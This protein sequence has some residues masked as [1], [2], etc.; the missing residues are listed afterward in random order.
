MADAL[1]LL[2]TAA[3]SALVVGAVGCSKDACNTYQDDVTAKLVQCGVTA[4]ST[5]PLPSE[6]TAP[7]AD[8]AQCLD[9]CIPLIDCQCWRTPSMA[10]DD[11][12]R[13]YLDCLNKCKNP[14]GTTSSSSSSSSS[15]G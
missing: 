13:K 4:A 7:A 12:N 14:N 1:K 5:T 8:L 2:L 15:G 3:C 6:C 9:L 10:C 11:V